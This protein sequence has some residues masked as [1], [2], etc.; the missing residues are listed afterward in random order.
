MNTAGG[1]YSVSKFNGGLLLKS[2]VAGC[3]A[4]YPNIPRIHSIL[5]KFALHRSLARSVIF[6]GSFPTSADML[7]N[8]HIIY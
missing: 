3:I 6:Q 7:Q 5:R 4:H 2:H 1:Q 8:G